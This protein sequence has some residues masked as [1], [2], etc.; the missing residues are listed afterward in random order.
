MITN[1]KWLKTASVQDEELLEGETITDPG[2]FVSRIKET[3][4]LRTS[5]H[6]S[7]DYL[8][9]LRSIDIIWNGIMLP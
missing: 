1:G 9:R 6:L 7:R 3:G 5:S 2:S 4:R 8:T